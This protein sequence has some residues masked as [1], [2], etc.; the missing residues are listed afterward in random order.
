M[1][2]KSPPHAS[3]GR[4]RLQ[5]GTVVLLVEVKPV[6]LAFCRPA[7]NFYVLVPVRSSVSSFGI[8]C[9]VRDLV[10]VALRST[11]APTKVRRCFCTIPQFSSADAGWCLNLQCAWRRKGGQQSF[12][13][14]G[15]L[16]CSCRP[17]RWLS[18]RPVPTTH[19][20]LMVTD[21]SARFPNSNST[22]KFL[23]A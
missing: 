9:L 7:C 11:R 12:F 2:P 5:R 19:I 17:C 15:S 14:S 10:Q 13:D 16:L 23:A 6:R 20:M 22:K 3:F 8:G 18:R 21:K 1:T 4:V